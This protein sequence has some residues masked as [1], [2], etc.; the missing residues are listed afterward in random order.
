MYLS[1]KHLPRRAFLRGVGVALGLPLLDAMVPAFASELGGADKA[2]RLAF[3]YVP[4]G[5]IMDSWTPKSAGTDFE[6]PATI[7]AL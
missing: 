4:N 1:R 6:F 2:L 5:I 7:K 3:A